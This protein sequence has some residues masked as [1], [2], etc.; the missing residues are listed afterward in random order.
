MS[1]IGAENLACS[2]RKSHT[3]KIS[4]QFALCSVRSGIIG[5]PALGS[6]DSL[7]FTQVILLYT[8]N[9]QKHVFSSIKEDLKGKQ[10]HLKGLRG[11][12]VVEG[13]TKDKNSYAII[14]RES[15]WLKS[16]PSVGSN[17]EAINSNEL[18]GHVGDVCLIVLRSPH[19]RLMSQ[20]KL[21]VS[22]QFFRKA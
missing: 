13:T 7:H 5:R 8:H 22:S 17:F 19:S 21:V 6:F 1:G 16:C 14:L 11:M 15:L 18:R 10:K 4:F 2:C 3:T 12:W 9:P 20:L